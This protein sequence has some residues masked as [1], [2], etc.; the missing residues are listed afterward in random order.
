MTDILGGETRQ[1]IE[2]LAVLLNTLLHCIELVNEIRYGDRELSIIITTTELTQVTCSGRQVIN[3]HLVICYHR[4]NQLQ[5]STISQIR[6]KDTEFNTVITI[7]C[8]TEICNVHNICQL[9]ESE[10]RTVTGGTCQCQ[11]QYRSKPLMH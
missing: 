2:R 4:I 8:N 1:L 5:T 6:Y 3:D 9:A 11:C 7:Q 10:V